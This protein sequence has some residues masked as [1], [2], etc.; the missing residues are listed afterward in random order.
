MHIYLRAK[1]VRYQVYP[2]D[3]LECHVS[4]WLCNYT[5]SI[6]SHM[7]NCEILN[8]KNK[9]IHFF[10]TRIGNPNLVLQSRYKLSN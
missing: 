1:Y 8:K 3:M 7:F 4:V 9:Q 5:I 10:I 6:C 2:K